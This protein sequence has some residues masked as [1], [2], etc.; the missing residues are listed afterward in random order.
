MIDTKEAYMEKL[1]AKLKE[2]QADIDKLKAKAAQSKA[3]IKIQINQ[4]IGNLEGK[5]QEIQKK[6]HELGQAS[7]SAWGDIKGGVEQAWGKLDKA[8]K[9]AISKFS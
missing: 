3:D 9:A 2:W 7:E 4:Q 8:F 1:E 6:L 5:S